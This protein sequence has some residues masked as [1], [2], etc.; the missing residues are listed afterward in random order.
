LG[1]G[2]GLP[3]VFYYDEQYEPKTSRYVL[4]FG[5]DCAVLAVIG[6]HNGVEV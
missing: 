4:G 6:I 1:G 2:V 3:G 5:Q